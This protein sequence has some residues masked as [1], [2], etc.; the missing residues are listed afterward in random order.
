[1]TYIVEYQ[2]NYSELG[3]ILSVFRSWL[4]THIAR[5]HDEEFRKYA[6]DCI[7]GNILL[8][9]KCKAEIKPMS[10]MRYSK[11]NTH[12]V[13]YHDICLREIEA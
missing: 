1:M 8:C 6:T 3:K 4:D 13:R 7:N 12:Y 2:L 9:W 11:N 10:L 5:H